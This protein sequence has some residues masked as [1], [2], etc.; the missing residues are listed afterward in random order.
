MRKLYTAHI[1]PI[2]NDNEERVWASEVDPGAFAGLRSRLADALR[3]AADALMLIGDVC[4]ALNF[5]ADVITAV[6]RLPTFVEP[7]PPVEVRVAMEDLTPSEKFW[8]WLLERYLER[9]RA[10]LLDAAP[11]LTEVL[12]LKPKLDPRIREDLWLV[13]RNVPSDTRPPANTSKLIPH[14]LA[15]SAIASSRYLAEL[16]G[17]GRERG[18][19]IGILRLAC[20]LHDFGKPE[21][22]GRM[23]REGRPVGHAKPSA[24]E[25]RAMFREV[26]E[27]LRGKLGEAAWLDEL[28]KALDAVCELIESHHVDRRL[29]SVSIAGAS[30]DLDRLLRLLR[31]ADRDASQI[32]RLADVAVEPVA[33]VLGEKPETVAAMVRESGDRAWSYWL[34]IDD[35]KIKEASEEAAKYLLTRAPLKLMQQPDERMDEM[36]GAALVDIRG[37]QRFIRRE[38]L[39]TM[40]GASHEVL[41]YCHFEIPRRIVARLGLPPECIIYAGGGTVYLIAPLTLLSRERLDEVLSCRAG[42]VELEVAVAYEPLGTYWQST[43]R[44]LWSRM[45]AVKSML[46]PKAKTLLGVE[47]E[48]SYC[49][50][51]PAIERR[52][53]GWI[54]EECAALTEAGSDRHFQ[55][56]LEGLRRSPALS[57][58]VPEWKKISQFVMEWLAGADIEEAGPREMLNLALIKADGN[59]MGSFMTSAVSPSDAMLRSAI[60]DYAL[61]RGVYELYR[62]LGG[63]IGG[64][65]LS[66]DV[67]RR[68][69]LDLA[70]LYTGLLYVGGDDM[71]AIWPARLAFPAAMVLSY[72]FW[73]EL[74]GVRQLSIGIASGKPRQNVWAIVDTASSLLDLCKH[75]ARRDLG[76]KDPA[77][78]SLEVI[79]LLSLLYAD[80]GVPLPSWVDE[81]IGA[82]A[83]TAQPITITRK[84]DIAQ[85]GSVW[86][87]AALIMDLGGSTVK[88]R[89]ERLLRLAATGELAG[90]AERLRDVAKEVY[91]AVSCGDLEEL[92][93][94][95]AAYAAYRMARSTGWESEVYRL[96]SAACLAEP[97]K[98]APLLDIFLLAKFL[99]G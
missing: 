80:T 90:R 98:P 1:V 89:V 19:G 87:L 51:K 74:G 39:R 61:K 62:L 17:A 43:A 97:P 81:L 23:L 84:V 20:L 78:Y 95:M 63:L 46:K 3:G 47:V 60:V 96:I 83:Y 68:V 9:R 38:D 26:L 4:D 71:M 37:I 45:S 49:G 29:G 91:E 86:Y 33:K 31:D 12:F 44:R 18:I 85:I 57:D 66:E 30:V 27:R 67:K 34:G 92:T 2:I 58:I 73:R 59:M 5:L 79:G 53:D 48:C 40:V 8:W 72:W 93:R 88:E 10:S 13:F 35:E 76:G 75:R 15:T 16:G 64:E 82:E 50:E 14:L 69:K 36:I 25:A 77:D 21:A 65:G 55:A 32:D 54:C 28:A 56:K 24:D 42:G 41:E 7:L 94:V 11:G 70:R 99:A 22:W 6:Y 52:E